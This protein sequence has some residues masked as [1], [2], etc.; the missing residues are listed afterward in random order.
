[1][2]KLSPLELSTYG[3]KDAFASIQPPNVSANYKNSSREG[4]EYR[5]LNDI[6][7]HVFYNSHAPLRTPYNL[8][9]FR[10]FA[11]NGKFINL[12]RE[13]P[14]ILDIMKN[15][16]QIYFERIIEPGM[17]P[18]T[19]LRSH[20][21]ELTGILNPDFL[22]ANEFCERA[23]LVRES[24]LTK[25]KTEIP[26]RIRY[27][28]VYRKRDEER[29]KMREIYRVFGIFNRDPQKNA[30]KK[31]IK[32]KKIRTFRNILYQPL[33][34]SMRTENE[35]LKERPLM[36]LYIKNPEA[37]YLS[38]LIMNVEKDYFGGYKTSC[39]K[40]LI[41][42]L[43]VIFKNNSAP[44]YRRFINSLKRKNSVK[45]SIIENLVNISATKIN[46][47]P[48][49]FEFI[50]LDSK[51]LEELASYYSMDKKLEGTMILLQK[52]YAKSLNDLINET[53]MEMLRTPGIL[54]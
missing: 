46:K 7:R 17:S 49:K 3:I 15:I 31:R 25:G 1:M 2:E 20:M 4:D 30:D 5:A 54:N 41:D 19:L 12:V 50:S 33:I 45:N 28:E 23:F 39:R 48:M 29:R 16:E 11:E 22:T 34:D 10:T 8:F 27:W 38:Q 51:R 13:K 36:Q 53:Y 43:F 18:I 44:I 9:Q 6:I 47:K 52:R 14:K 32:A 40:S 26:D 35:L 37:R 42:K 24:L 21:K